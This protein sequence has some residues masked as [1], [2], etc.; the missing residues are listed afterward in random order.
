[1]KKNWEDRSETDRVLIPLWQ[2]TFDNGGGF[3][4][5]TAALDARQSYLRKPLIFGEMLLQS[6][7]STGMENR[8]YFV[9]I[10]PDTSD[11]IFSADSGGMVEECFRYRYDG[12]GTL[13]TAFVLSSWTDLVLSGADK[14]LIMGTDGYVQIGA[15]VVLG[16]QQTAIADPSGGSTVD[17]EAR[18]AIGSI[19]TAMRTHGLIATT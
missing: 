9:R 12:G 7:V 15:N 14:G 13:P 8:R 11:L 10:D 19:L 18:T 2:M 5:F 4:A 17:A 16:P 6:E 1:M 3:W